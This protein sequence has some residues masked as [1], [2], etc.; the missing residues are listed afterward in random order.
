MPAAC[1][2]CA[3]CGALDIPEH[4]VVDVPCPGCGAD[5]GS[6]GLVQC[7]E[8]LDPCVP[9]S[10]ARGTDFSVW[11]HAVEKGECVFEQMQRHVPVIL[12]VVPLVGMLVAIYL[13]PGRGAYGVIS[14]VRSKAGYELIDIETYPEP[15]RG[16]R[17]SASLRQTGSWYLKGF[18]PDRSPGQVFFIPSVPRRRPP[19]EV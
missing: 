7:A 3:E 2:I 10:S 12:D 18:R 9:W 5:N 4:V 13:G 11:T 1:Y 6:M 15:T 16:R 19:H 14:R 17:R 8:C